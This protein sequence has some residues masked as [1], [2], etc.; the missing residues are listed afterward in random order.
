MIFSLKTISLKLLMTD[1]KNINNLSGLGRKNILDTIYGAHRD[2]KTG[3]WMFGDS[4]LKLS[5]DKISVGNVNWARTPGLFELMF[6][7][8]PQNFDRTELDIYKHILQA[9]NA[10]R[11]NYKADG[12]IKG[13]KAYKY[14]YII[15]KLINDNGSETLSNTSKSKHTGSGMMQLNEYKTNY[16][17]WDDPNELVDRLRLLI[18]SQAAGHNNH[19]N[20][21]VSII[22]ELRE[23]NIII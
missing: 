3:E 2:V 11:R 15:S 4:T 19:N 9:T 5:E 16:L 13:T 12:Q 22:E 23:A 18:A 14:K 17:Y 21:I 7:I 6:Y 10:Y 8:K 20:E 1:T